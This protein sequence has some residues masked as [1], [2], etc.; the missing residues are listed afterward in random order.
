[1]HIFEYVPSK[2]IGSPRPWHSGIGMSLRVNSP[3]FHLDVGSTQQ[4]GNHGGVRIRFRIAIFSLLPKLAT[5]PAGDPP[6]RE[7]ISYAVMR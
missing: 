6:N 7:L 1:M 3:A 5:D 2:V 4:T